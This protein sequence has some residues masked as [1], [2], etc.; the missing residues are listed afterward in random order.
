MTMAA[1]G[2]GDAPRSY[3]GPAA[4]PGELLTRWNADPAVLIALAL[5][6]ALAIQTLPSDPIN[7]R[8]KLAFI[9]LLALLYVSPFCAW[10]SSLFA[11]RVSHHLLLGLVAAPLAA[12]A[13][14]RRLGS[15]PGGLIG[16]TAIATAAMWAWHAPRLYAW[17]V[18]SDGGYWLMQASIFLTALLFW[19]RVFRSSRPAAI[20][21]LLAAMI[22]MGLLG[23][24]VTMASAPL[25][26]P[27]FSTTAAWALSPI[28]DQQLGGL[29]MWAPACAAYLVVALVLLRRQLGEE[30]RA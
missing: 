12:Q 22:A 23:A 3:C 8:R 26:A 24:I 4:G 9:A 25:Y 5:G 6:L 17:A 10:G 2:M 19:D 20:C 14:H 15:W 13:W 18:A 1:T 27:H 7:A 21:G 16:W 11:V 29:I 30:A 28:E